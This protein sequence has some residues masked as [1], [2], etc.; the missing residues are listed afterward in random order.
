MQLCS[1]ADDLTTR[2]RIRLISLLCR[3]ACCLALTL[4]VTTQARAEKRVALVFGVSNYQNVPRLPNPG[5]DAAAMSDVL[6]RQ[7]NFDVVDL[8]MDV[9]ISEMRRA[10]REF[11]AVAADADIALVYYSGYGIEVNGVNY[12]IP[13]DARLQSDFDVEDETVSLD[14]ILQ[15]INPARK[16]RLVILD[17]CRDDPFADKMSRSASTR[18]I[19]RGLARIEPGMSDTLIA[20]A[21]KAGA[22][23]IEGNGTHSPFSAAL[24]N[25][26]ATP[27]LDLR[28]ALGRVRDEVLKSTGRRQEPFVY[29]SLG[30]DTLALVPI[31]SPPVDPNVEA[32]RDYELAAQSG[33]RDAWTSFLHAH[34]DGIYAGFA[35]A[36]LDKLQAAENASAKAELVKQQAEE[37]A[38]QKS[39][40]LKRQI[41]ARAAQQTEQAKLQI[42]EQARR[43]FDQER[44]R[45]S[46]QAE[47]ALDDARRQLA[48]AQRQA[49]DAA[50]E[51]ERAKKQAAAE[52]QQQIEAAK[53]EAEQRAVAALPP[54]PAEPAP[55]S[56]ARTAAPA[57]DPAD[58]ARLLQVHLKRVGCDP[59]ALDGSWT[60]GSQRALGD[61]NKHAGTTFDVKVASIDALDAVRMTH[62]RV[63]P[64]VC[65]KGKRIAGERCIP[66]VCEANFAIDDQGVCRKRPEPSK[67]PKAVSRAM[68]RQ[69]PAA[70]ARPASDGGQN[71]CHSF[72]GKLYCQ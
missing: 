53:R 58:I 72:E 57:M 6:K 15:A 64:L 26:L 48:E 13:A 24:L 37:L 19:G 44:Q 68:S 39:E 59:G 9:G 47:R 63:C 10:V 38:R 22:V 12:V 7:M 23:A 71:G 42:S 28:L 46:E 25:H 21:A 52:A 65:S 20:F 18:A 33:T 70:P 56:P 31:A 62:D 8:H 14:R 4:L 17:A 36:A 60:D 54:A 49:G 69:E 61:F 2:R 45:I 5:N 30:G 3:L 41:E 1:F 11:A 27:G 34:S 35:H 67:K 32:R 50:A 55:S 16:L 43:E 51:I 40:E 66:I 29:G